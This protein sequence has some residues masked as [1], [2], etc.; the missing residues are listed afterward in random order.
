MKYDYYLIVVIR[1]GL[2]AALSVKAMPK[3]AILI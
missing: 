1:K 3:T 2:S